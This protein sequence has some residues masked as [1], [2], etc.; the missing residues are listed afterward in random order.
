MSISCSV[1]A[2]TRS[3]V[4]S[5]SDVLGRRMLRRCD[6][7][8][9][10]SCEQ[11]R[12]AIL[13]SRF[14]TSKAEMDLVVKAI[15]HNQDGF[16]DLAEFL[17][18]LSVDSEMI[19]DDKK[20]AQEIEKQLNLCSCKEK[21]PVEE[22]INNSA[23]ETSTDKERPS[24][25]H[26]S[27]PNV[28]MQL[29]DITPHNIKLLKRINGIV[30]PVNYN[31]RFYEDV[32]STTNIA[33]FA[34]FNDIVVGAMCCRILLV[35]NEKKLYIMT[36]G[37]LPNYRRF[38]LGTMMLE[39]VFDYCRKNSSIS[40]IF[41]H[42]QVNNDVAL[43]FYRKFGFEVHSVVENYYKRITPADAFLLVKRLDGARRNDNVKEV[44]LV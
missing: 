34:Y 38:G 14:K 18:A 1:L 35:N 43:E 7:D 31:A 15:D 20:I 42:V 5:F 12:D 32:L 25:V 26:A 22:M 33:K 13:Y 21:Y 17:H 44:Q 19:T 3:A 4:F 24:V 41:L 27:R 8:E 11:F 16:V 2:F 6:C 10:L 29:G 39:H 30:F 37:C 28:R 36:L 23:H 9:R 40:G